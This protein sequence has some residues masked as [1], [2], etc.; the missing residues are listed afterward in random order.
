M[1]VETARDMVPHSYCARDA[2]WLNGSLGNWL[3]SSK[4][5]YFL[6]SMSEYCVNSWTWRKKKIREVKVY[7]TSRISDRVKALKCGVSK[8]PVL[9][10]CG[11][12]YQALD[13]VL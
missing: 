12:L 2:V 9:I 3:G 4:V 8:I 13:Q 7:H 1:D 11:H 10:I 5:A 6:L